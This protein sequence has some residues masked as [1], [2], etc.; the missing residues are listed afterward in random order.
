MTEQEAK[1]AGGVAIITGAGSGIGMGLAK[2]A[3]AIGMTVIVADVAGD[4]AEAVAGEIRAL[5]GAAEA[6]RVDVSRAE[7]LDRLADAVFERHGAVRLLVN[8]AGIETLGHVWEI[9]A[10]RW[11]ATLDVN[12]HG[13]VH[14][15]RAFLPRM[16]ASG[17]E[18]WVANTAS[19]AAFGMIP[20]QVA[21]VM[22]KHAVQAFSEGL[23]LEMDYVGAPIHVSSVL[24]GMVKTG[25]FDEDAGAGESDAA[26]PHRQGMRK[27]MESYGMELAEACERIMQQIAANQFWVSTHPEQLKDLIAG[28]IEFLGA[29]LPPVLNERAR[30]ML[31]Q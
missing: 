4:R 5:G 6:M 21:Y 27:R 29:G 12:I 20:T 7:E 31:Q 24:P 22:T 30:Q 8:N 23:Y 26:R 19:G 18:A 28:R 14:G 2:R 16:I 11:D 13:I 25:I 1:F 10:A 15:V 9:P 17:Q 3:G